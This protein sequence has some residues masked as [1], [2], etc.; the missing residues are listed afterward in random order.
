MDAIANP[1]LN[2]KK[3]ATGFKD[4][5]VIPVESLVLDDTPGAFLVGLLNGSKSVCLNSIDVLLTT[6]MK[7]NNSVSWLIILVSIDDDYRTLKEAVYREHPSNAFWG[8][9]QGI[10]EFGRGIWSGATG[11]FVLPYRGAKK[12]RF[13]GFLKGIGIGSL[14]I[15]LKPVGGVFDLFAKTFE[16]ILQ[17]LGRGYLMQTRS[18]PIKKENSTAREEALVQHWLD[19]NR[20][21]AYTKEK[22]RIITKDGRIKDRYLMLGINGFII[23]NLSK[24]ELPQYRHRTIALVEISEVLVPVTPETNFIVCTKRPN[25][26]GQDKFHF[27]APDR[28]LFLVK[29]QSFGVKER[30]ISKQKME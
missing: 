29:L 21:E 11:I 16:G 7:L 23:L 13:L 15:P 9:F 22:V 3:L 2:M 19:A 4:L 27:I 14:G 30:E 28:H 6:F 25:K 10:R 12:E 8:L 5:F 24:L 17:T 26:D 1:L 20:E 18:H